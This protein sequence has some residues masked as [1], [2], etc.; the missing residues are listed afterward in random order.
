MDSFGPIAALIF[1]M[2]G[3]VLDTERTYFYAWQQTA[4]TMGA[5]LPDACLPLLSGRH[6]QEIEQFL[7]AH[8]GESFDLAY[9]RAQSGV[10]W[11]AHVATEG[12]A[13]KTGFEDLLA[14]VRQ[15]QIPY[16]LATNSRAINVRECLALAGIPEVFSIIITRDDVVQG[17]PA[18]DIFLTAAKR[19]QVP[20]HECLILED[21]AT[22]IAAAK[23]AGGRAVFIP[24]SE[25]LD[26]RAEGCGDYRMKDLTEVLQYLKLSF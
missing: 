14:F 4:Q 5:D 16:C 22:G 6:Y 12:I 23:A 21:S 2:D 17:K 8:F 11:R 26:L 15:Q 10:Y 24:S 9:F 7:R 13:I 20:I 19:L 18:P 1:D 3:L 25:S